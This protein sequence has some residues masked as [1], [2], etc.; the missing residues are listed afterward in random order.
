VPGF[1]YTSLRAALDVDLHFGSLALRGSLGYRL[2]IGGYGEVSEAG[3][4]PRM[5]GYGTE[6]SLGGEY[7]ISKEVG[8]E[9]SANLR[10]YLLQMNSRPE[11][12]RQGTSAVAGGAVDLYLGGYFGLNITL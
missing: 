11:D 2:P 4:F 3:W 8:F 1:S 5:E 9:V 6:G 12:A 10:R 7:R